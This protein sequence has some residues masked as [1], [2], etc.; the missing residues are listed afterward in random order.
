[1]P[2]IVD[3]V[4]DVAQL[5]KLAVRIARQALVGDIVALRGDLGTGKTTFVRAAL[6][7]LG[8]M[9]EVPSPTFTLA[10]VYDVEALCLWHF[11][12][13]RIA[14]PQEAIELGIDEAFADGVSFIEWPDRLAGLLP[15]TRLDVT[16]S[17]VDAPEL[18]HIDVRGG[19]AWARRLADLGQPS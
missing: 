8:W 4:V 3:R 11:D 13:Y 7:G 10:Q 19:A 18:R 15:A 6:R 16:L 14:H 5:E 9:A 17:F 2:N 1:M 12:L